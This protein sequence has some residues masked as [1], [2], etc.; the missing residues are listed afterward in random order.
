MSRTDVHGTVADGFEQV[1]EAFAVV[2]AEQDGQVGSQLAGGRAGD[3]FGR[4][5]LFRAGLAVF[6]L[7]GVAGTGSALIA[8]R[9]LQGVAARDSGIASGLVNTSQQIGGAL[10][11]AVL[12][13]IAA[14]TTDQPQGTPVHNALTSGYTAGMLGAGAFYLAAILTAVLLLRPRPVSRSAESLDSIPR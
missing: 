1:R 9:V 7:G 2:V 8:A 4:R 11:L 13:G 10:G 12:A 5:R 3:L 6:L 14:A